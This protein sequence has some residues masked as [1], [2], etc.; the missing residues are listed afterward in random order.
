VSPLAD[1]VVD[2]EG[3]G[4]EHDSGED[5]PAE[6]VAQEVG[7]VDKSQRDLE[8]VTKT[9]DEAPNSVNVTTDNRVQLSGREV[10]VC[11]G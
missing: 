8:S 9:P 4:E 7:S 1:E 6:V 3:D 5:T 10:S 2:S 11:R